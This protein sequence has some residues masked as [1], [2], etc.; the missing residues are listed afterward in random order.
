MPSHRIPG[1]V[2]ERNRLAIITGNSLT[3]GLLTR[4]VVTGT[5]GSCIDVLPFSYTPKHSI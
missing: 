4:V 1:S 2:S 3:Q 5:E